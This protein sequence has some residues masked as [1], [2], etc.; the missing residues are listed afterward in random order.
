MI[1]DSGA[2]SQALEGYKSEPRFDDALVLAA[3]GAYFNPE[4]V[5]D[6]EG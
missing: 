5:V 2:I 3:R 1:G 6:W 4:D